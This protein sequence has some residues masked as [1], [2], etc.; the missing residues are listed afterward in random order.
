MFHSRAKCSPRRPSQPGITYQIQVYRQQIEWHVNKTAFISIWWELHF[1]SQ[2]R[3]KPLLS[4]LH[5]ISLGDLASLFLSIMMY[6]NEYLLLF[7]CYFLMEISLN[8]VT[9]DEI[10]DKK[11]SLSNYHVLLLMFSNR[12]EK[13]NFIWAAAKQFDWPIYASPYRDCG[14]DYRSTIIGW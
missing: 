5:W 6:L 11:R 13:C 7:D 4:D 12:F 3:R 1:F 9:S 14:D 2:A 8:V 10:S